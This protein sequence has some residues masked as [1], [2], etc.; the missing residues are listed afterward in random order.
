MSHRPQLRIVTEV[1]EPAE[2]AGLPRAWRVPVVAKAL[3]I[4]EA[5]FYR[6]IQKGRITGI[7]VPEGP[8]LITEEEVNRFLLANRTGGRDGDERKD[9]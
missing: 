7:R 5:T 8:L 3:S 4:P 9:E 2:L 1:E 6:L